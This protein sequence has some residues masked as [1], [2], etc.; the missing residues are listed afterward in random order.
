MIRIVY[1]ILTIAIKD[2]EM[3]YGNAN[4]LLGKSIFQFELLAQK[5]KTSKQTADALYYKY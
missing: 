5:R 3:R 4:L 1:T 2:L